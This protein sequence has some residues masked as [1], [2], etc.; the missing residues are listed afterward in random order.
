MLFHDLFV[1][2]FALIIDFFPELDNISGID[3]F[4]M[5]AVSKVSHAFKLYLVVLWVGIGHVET[6]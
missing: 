2:K 6:S 3:Q 1:I 4:L 5:C